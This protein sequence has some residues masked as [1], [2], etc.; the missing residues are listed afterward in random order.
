MFVGLQICV[1]LAQMLLLVFPH[2]AQPVLSVL[3]SLLELPARL[4]QLQE[5]VLQSRKSELQVRKFCTS[6][7]IHHNI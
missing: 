3:L 5:L 2:L 6:A 1:Q 4:P 7:C